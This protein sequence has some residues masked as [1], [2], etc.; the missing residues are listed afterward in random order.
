MKNKRIKLS[1]NFWVENMHREFYDKT[2]L[3]K[4][5]MIGKIYFPAN[6]ESTVFIPVRCDEETANALYNEEYNVVKVWINP[7]E[8]GIYCVY[9]KAMLCSIDDSTFSIEWSA[10][11]VTRDFALHY[12]APKIIDYVRENCHGI[13]GE[14]FLEYCDNILHGVISYD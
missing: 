11:H 4:E 9:F 5:A 1:S 8:V 12:L 7:E 3:E 14:K 10:G 13:N 2:P 6:S